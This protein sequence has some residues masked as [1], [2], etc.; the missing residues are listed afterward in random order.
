MRALAG[1]LKLGG[2]NLHRIMY[3]FFYFTEALMLDRWMKAGGMKHLHVHFASAAANVGLVLKMYAPIGLSMTVHGPDE[4]YDA[5]GGAHHQ[6][7]VVVAVP[8]A[9]DGFRHALIQR[10]AVCSRKPG[11][12]TVI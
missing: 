9:G 4:F 2:W 1:A 11:S 12:L 3:G 8:I 10:L 5:P 7:A 6:Q